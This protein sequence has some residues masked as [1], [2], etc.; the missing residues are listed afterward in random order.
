MILPLLLP[1]ALLAMSPGDDDVLALGGD[2][3][4][5]A[6]PVQLTAEGEPIADMT[7]PSPTLFDLDGDGMRELVIGDIFG[8]VRV[9]EPQAEEAGLAWS[10]CEKLQSD[11]KDLRL[12]N[13]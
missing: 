9:A 11:G 3:A 5:F 1:A 2:A 6:A 4:L 10:A 7:Y 13:W 8:S 12:N